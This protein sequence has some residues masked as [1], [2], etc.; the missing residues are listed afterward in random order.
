MSQI[1]NT[2]K[3]NTAMI[4]DTLSRFVD[5]VC[6]VSKTNID[7]RADMLNKLSVPV[8]TNIATGK[9]TSSNAIVSYRMNDNSLANCICKTNSLDVLSIN[10]IYT[11]TFMADTRVIKSSDFNTLLGF[12]YS[13]KFNQNGLLSG[14]YLAYAPSNTNQFIDLGDE[15][16]EISLFYVKANASGESFQYKAY[17]ID[18]NN[19]RINLI[20]DKTSSNYIIS[21]INN[22]IIGQSRNTDYTTLK[23]LIYGDSSASISAL[24]IDNLDTKLD[25]I[26][27]SL[28]KFGKKLLECNYLDTSVSP[29][30][31]KYLKF[32]INGSSNTYQE[33]STLNSNVPVYSGSSTNIPGSL[34]TLV[35]SPSSTQ[36]DTMNA[37]KRAIFNL[38]MNSYNEIVP[39]ISINSFTDNISVTAFR[40]SNDTFVLDIF[41]ITNTN[42]K[43]ISL[44]DMKFESI[45]Q[46]M[47]NDITK[48]FN[49]YSLLNNSL[50]V[51]N[52]I[53]Q[54]PDTKTNTKQFYVNTNTKQIL[55]YPGETISGKNYTSIMFDPNYTF[56]TDG[57]NLFYRIGNA[58]EDTSKGYMPSTVT[59][60]LNKKIYTGNVNSI[61]KTYIPARIVY[62]NYTRIQT[63]AMSYVSAASHQ[64][65]SKQIYFK[66]NTKITGETTSNVTTTNNT[67]NSTSL[68]S[69]NSI[70]G[71]FWGQ[72]AS[73]SI[74]G[75]IDKT[76]VLKSTDNKTSD[77]SETG[78]L[79]VEVTYSTIEEKAPAIDLIQNLCLQNVN[80]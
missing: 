50:Y 1:Q 15:N 77:E 47:S 33:T 16:K 5:T 65:V 49:A 31:I 24:T 73:T 41:D 46:L 66:A 3:Q 55:S 74:E 39:N 79:K 72:K 76:Y 56:Y 80:K 40:D 64:L 38:M 10:K 29:S 12:E 6:A 67:N 59:F 17:T 18:D 9:Y 71:G 35:A 54:I 37:K 75:S 20:Y 8:T 23:N 19:N 2:V 13:N 45:D 61:Q 25:P 78:I 26:L 14:S 22:N 43:L 60:D 68:T 27:N 69:N 28:Y 44:Q 4:G 62:T 53:D 52:Q 21:D 36:T 51:I 32:T 63:P 48:S 70:G 30:V 11:N 34:L 7:T 42:N 58:G 57:I